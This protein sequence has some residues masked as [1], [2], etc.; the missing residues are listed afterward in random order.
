M[1]KFYIGLDVGTDSCGIAATDENYNLIKY[2]GND[3]WAV[4]LFDEAQSAKQRRVFRTARRRLWRRQQRIDLLQSL[5]AEEISK[6][7]ATFFLRLNNSIFNRNDK[8]ERLCDGY[9]LFGDDGY[10]DKEFHKK[11]PTI[12]HLRRELT[13]KPA[14]DVRFL[15]LALHNIIKRRGHFLYEGDFGDNLQFVPLFNADLYFI[16]HVSQEEIL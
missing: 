6:S 3:M 7:D 16:K 4:S 10:T 9:C 11:Y 8:D 14:K 13:Q 2:R 12:Y 1:E 5:F 15:Y